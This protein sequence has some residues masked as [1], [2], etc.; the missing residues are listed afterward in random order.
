MSPS[1]S[2]VGGAFEQPGHWDNG[3]ASLVH[4]TAVTRLARLF[5]QIAQIAF[6]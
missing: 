3:P 5:L 1:N 2:Y 4:G 6:C